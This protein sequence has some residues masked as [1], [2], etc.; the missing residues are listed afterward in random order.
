MKYYKDYNTYIEDEYLNENVVIDW[1]FFAKKAKKFGVDIA[2]LR[3]E[4][5]KRKLEL[6]N[7][8]TDSGEDSNF[9][10]ENEI[11]ELQTYETSAIAKENSLNMWLKK[12]G[13]SEYLRDVA[14]QAKYEQEYKNSEQLRKLAKDSISKQQF[15]DSMRITSKQI[16]I[17]DAQNK[18]TNQILNRNRNNKTFDL[19]QFRDMAAMK[20]RQNMLSKLEM[21]KQ[22]IAHKDFKDKTNISTTK[23]KLETDKMKL[24]M[25]KQRADL[26]K[27]RM[28][29][30]FGKPLTTQSTQTRTRKEDEKPI[31]FTKNPLFGANTV[32]EEDD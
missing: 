31:D 7:A 1:L 30:T 3:F 23:M 21:E 29:A 10:S 24:D 14:E 25:D 32:E 20:N 16:E 13:N 27:E 19:D 4:A 5:E 9:F 11:T 6:K 22:L 8:K 2:N 18:E 28:N 17:L 26:N 12:R 15:K